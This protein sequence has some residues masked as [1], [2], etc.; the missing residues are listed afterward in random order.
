MLYIYLQQGLVTMSGGQN[1]S[2]AMFFECLTE[3]PNPHSVGRRL[4]GASD[5]GT[6]RYPLGGAV[7]S[8]SPPHPAAI[9]PSIPGAPWQNLAREPRFLG[10]SCPLHLRHT[11]MM[12]ENR[13]VTPPLS[14]K[15]KKMFELQSALVCF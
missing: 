4:R 8:Y 3:Q 12:S 13:E 2:S 14:P 1:S 6:S 15:P 10:S 5:C 11:I 7:S 9:A